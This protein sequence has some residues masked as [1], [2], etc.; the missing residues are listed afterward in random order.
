MS[1]AE[2]LRKLCVLVIGAHEWMD[3]QMNTNQ[4]LRRAC[5]THT[6]SRRRVLSVS[7]SAR[8]APSPTVH[9]HQHLVA[10]HC[11][12]AGRAAWK[13]TPKVKANH[14]VAYVQDTKKK[15]KNHIKSSS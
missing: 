3:S 7:G 12:K 6:A 11:T 15:K 5:S 1:S 8:T 14:E 10:P 2:R 4:K 9:L 13:G